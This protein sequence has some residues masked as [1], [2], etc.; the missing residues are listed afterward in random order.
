M[1]M[2]WNKTKTV[3]KNNSKHNQIIIEKKLKYEYNLFIK[4]YN[5]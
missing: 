4:F 5:N 1:K 2:K 3:T